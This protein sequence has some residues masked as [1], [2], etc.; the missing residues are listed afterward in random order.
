MI[1][2]GA[3]GYTAYCCCTVLAPESIRHFSKFKIISSGHGLFPPHHAYRL[4]SMWWRKRGEVVVNCV[5]GVC[6]IGT[7]I[8]RI[9]LCSFV[10]EKE[11]RYERK[12]VRKTAV[13][14][15][16]AQIRDSTIVMK[17]RRLC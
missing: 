17:M 10:V 16:A 9:L 15:C 3:V 14:C 7:R 6:C 11:N 4:D 13:S 2:D 12:A 1:T 5:C 8:Y